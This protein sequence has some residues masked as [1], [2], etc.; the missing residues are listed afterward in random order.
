MMEVLS[1][2]I[3]YRF[4]YRIKWMN[5]FLNERTGR[6]FAKAASRTLIAFFLNLQN[7]FPIKVYGMPWKYS[8]SDLWLRKKL[9]CEYPFKKYNSMY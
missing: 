7:I 3:F 5:S 4:K 8:Q 2:K 9:A 6:T 1:N